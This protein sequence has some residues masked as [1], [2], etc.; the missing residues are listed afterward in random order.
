MRGHS[1]DYLDADGFRLLILI[2]RSLPDGY[3]NPRPG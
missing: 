3:I 2:F 1:K